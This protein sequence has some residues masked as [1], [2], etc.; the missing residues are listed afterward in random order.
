MSKRDGDDVDRSAR[1]DATWFPERPGRPRRRPLIRRG[2]RAVNWLSDLPLGLT[3]GVLLAI[4]IALG[5]VY[6]HFCP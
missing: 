1:V 6:M 3:V 4:G 5:F 2:V